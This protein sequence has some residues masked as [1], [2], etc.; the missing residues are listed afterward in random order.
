VPNSISKIGNLTAYQEL[1][2]AVRH[3]PP[4]PVSPLILS[5]APAPTSHSLLLHRLCGERSPAEFVGFPPGSKREGGR[6]DLGHDG[7][8]EVG[9]R[10]VGVGDQGPRQ[11]LG[12][13]ALAVVV[14]LAQ[15]H[16][17][18]AHCVGLPNGVPREGTLAPVGVCMRPSS[19]VKLDSH[20]VCIR[21]VWEGWYMHIRTGWS[22]L[23]CLP[24]LPPHYPPNPSS[25][26]FSPPPP[27]P[28]PAIK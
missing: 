18:V 22:L 24:P 9:S 20:D 3:P 6:G 11:H 2:G 25:P 14:A 4:L 27:P 28:L 5:S 8:P 7:L 19:K 21:S 1:S 26:H 12:G 16:E 17:L 23:S 13:Q 10:K 15:V